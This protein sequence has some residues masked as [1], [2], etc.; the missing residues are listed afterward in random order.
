MQLRTVKMLSTCK[1]CPDGVN[2]RPYYKGE[3]YNLP[4]SLGRAFVEELK[5]AEDAIEVP[6]A[7]S[8]EVPKAK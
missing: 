2:V 6:K 5:V 7:A 4:A 8:K 1:G 3:E